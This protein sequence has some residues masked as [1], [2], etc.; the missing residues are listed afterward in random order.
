MVVSVLSLPFY[1]PWK[2][3]HQHITEDRLYNPRDPIL[4]QVLRDMKFMPLRM[5]YE[6]KSG[7][8]QKLIFYLKNYMRLVF[9]P[10]RF[11][12]EQE[13]FPDL[14]FWR[15]YERHNAEIAGFHLDMRVYL[16]FV[17][18]QVHLQ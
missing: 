14:V 9:K 3:L 15:E 4:K 2:L 7:T 17:N 12:R 6:S 11:P 13:V 5:N 16:N 1:R 8:E 18:F 10:M